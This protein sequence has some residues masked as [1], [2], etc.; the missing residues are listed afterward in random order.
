[1]DLK[2][3]IMNR[4]SIRLFLPDAPARETI[5]R[6]VDAARWAPSWGNTQP[7]DIVYADG[8]KVEALTAAFVNEAKKGVTPRP[9][10]AMPWDFPPK[11]KERYRGVGRA[12]FT[13]LGIDRED[14]EGRREHY[15]NMYRLFGAPGIFYL[16]I[17]KELNEPYACLDLGSVGTTICYLAVA[18]GLG[19]IFLSASVHYPDIVREILAIPDSQ[20]IVMGVAVGKQ[21]PDAPASTFRSGREPLEN[22]FRIA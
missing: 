19:T 4:R 22:I 14:M 20:K 17:F 7:W 16:T 2:D 10:V 18:E 5:T 9:D 13:Q 8:E 1:M 15:M 3:A 6:I 11:F 12:L 21:H